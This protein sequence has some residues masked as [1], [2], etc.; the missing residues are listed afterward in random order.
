MDATE[1]KVAMFD[2][3]SSW[4][5]INKKQV[6][7]GLLHNFVVSSCLSKPHA[8][9]G[10]PG[11]LETLFLRQKLMTTGHSRAS[12]IPTVG[13]LKPGGPVPYF[14]FDHFR[15]C[16]AGQLPPSYEPHIARQVTAIRD[17]HWNLFSCLVY[18]PL[19]LRRKP[20]LIS[21]AF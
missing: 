4:R 16:D 18:C 10:Y 1:E 20:V 14:F 11:R 2:H 17:V 7:C 21:A 6:G 9:L 8:H 12:Q 3:A 5:L 13:K 15:V 19:Y